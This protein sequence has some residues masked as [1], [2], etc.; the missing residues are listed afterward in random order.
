[1]G[2]GRFLLVPCG[3]VAMKF[4]RGSALVSGGLSGVC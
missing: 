1:M 3:L 4:P 2:G